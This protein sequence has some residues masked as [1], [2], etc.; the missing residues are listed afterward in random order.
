[1]SASPEAIANKFI[2]LA[3]ENGIFVSNMKL[4]KLVYIAHG[5][6]LGYKDLPLSNETPQAWQYGPVFPSLYCK[7]RDYGASKV[8]RLIPGVNDLPE[9]SEEVQLIQ[10]VWES[11]GKLSAASLVSRTHAKGT[12]W[13]D[14]WSPDTTKVVIPNSSIKDHFKKLIAQ[15]TD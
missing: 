11:Y 3:L 7:L 4:Q 5:F 1:M 9:D 14:V 13:S 12:P 2:K 15:F 10:V 6:Y 8:D